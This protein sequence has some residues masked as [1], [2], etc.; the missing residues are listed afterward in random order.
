MKLTPRHYLLGKIGMYAAVTLAAVSVLL[1]VGA[2]GC[3]TVPAPTLVPYSEPVVSL[4][5]TPVPS[6]RT[7]VYIIS[8]VHEMFTLF[9]TVRVTN[10][11]AQ[12][13]GRW[14]ILLSGGG[15]RWSDKAPRRVE[16]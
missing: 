2:S 7:G 8:E 12:P 14:Y 16:R 10:W 15:D 5:A 4:D 9:D 3:A 13:D 1:L 6:T 11:V